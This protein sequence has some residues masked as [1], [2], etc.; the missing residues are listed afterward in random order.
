MFNVS[1][2]IDLFCVKMAEFQLMHFW[3]QFLL[4]KT[5]SMEDTDDKLTNKSTKQLMNFTGAK[6]D[7]VHLKSM[8]I[9]EERL[10]ILPQQENPKKS[11]INIDDELYQCIKEKDS[12]ING[13][14]NLSIQLTDM[15]MA[16]SILPKPDIISKPIQNDGPN[17]M[18]CNPVSIRPSQF[19][20]NQTTFND[21][22]HTNT[23]M[24]EHDV[25]QVGES[26]KEFQLNISKSSDQMSAKQ[27]DISLIVVEDTDDLSNVSMSVTNQTRR[28]TMH[29]P[30]K[31][32]YATNPKLNETISAVKEIDPFDI[33]LQNA[34]L[35]DI[36]FIEYIKSLDYVNI[37]TRVRPIEQNTDLEIGDETFTMLKQIGQGSFGFVYR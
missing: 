35:D 27:D 5:E 8:H 28:E 26:L 18:I 21:T 22:T 23:K 31:N 7:N 11:P 2:E 14:L 34:L 24:V 9:K 25:E 19:P 3:F 1:I 16:R 12:D 37:T 6:D 30:F 29:S 17:F 32:R 20:M 13:F 33:H 10:S 4:Y 15:E 36:D